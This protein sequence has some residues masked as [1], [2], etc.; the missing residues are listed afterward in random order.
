MVN[1]NALKTELYEVVHL[2]KNDLNQCNSFE[3]KPGGKGLQIYLQKYAYADELTGISR[4]YLVKD[5]ISGDL[6]AYFTLRTGLITVSRGF[7]KGFD[8]H[9]GIELANF[10]INEAYRNANE[11]IPNLGSYLFRRFI[12]PIVKEIS[13][14]VGAE[15]LYIY[16][17]PNDRLMAHYETMGF[18][19]APVKME[20]CVYRHV[21]PVYDAGCKFMYRKI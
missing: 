5:I 15:F 4:T 9:T 20:K 6:V 18:S 2:S 13:N 11:V 7:M 12:V 19:K 1:L 8:T 17:L 3:T 16:A 14:D 21:K 10:A